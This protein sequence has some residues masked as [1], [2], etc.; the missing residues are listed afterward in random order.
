MPTFNSALGAIAQK[1]KNTVA[2]TVSSFTAS[3]HGTVEA[4]HRAEDLA[5]SN[6]ANVSSWADSSSN[7]NTVTK[8]TAP[9]FPTYT[10]DW[11]NGHPAVY[12]S[13]NSWM[14]S[15]SLSQGNRT[16]TDAFIF[17][18]V[19]KNGAGDTNPRFFSGHPNS[20]SHLQIFQTSATNIRCRVGDATSR[21]VN[22][23]DVT[24]SP[25]II[26]LCHDGTTA[27][28]YVNSTTAGYS[29][30]ETVRGNLH[31]IGFNEFNDQ[32]AYN[33]DMYLAEC[34]VYSAL[35]S[36]QATII[37]ALADKYSITLA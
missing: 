24:T 21:D 18:I 5:L 26:S 25:S 35:T 27:N 23:I 30:A 9:D 3:D 17:M 34:V 28:I 8:S 14:R 29:D 32:S 7:S 37:Q 19:Q 33:N 10:A 6:G 22:G 20:S 15:G 2:V 13:S 12:F 11:S 31:Q 1:P 16:A 4:H 36:S